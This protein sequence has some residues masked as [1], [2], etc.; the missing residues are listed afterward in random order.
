VTIDRGAGMITS[1]RQPEQFVDAELAAPIG[2]HGFVTGGATLGSRYLVTYSATAARIADDPR[3][4]NVWFGSQSV[5][6]LIDWKLGA[7]RL[8]GS[9]AALRTKLGQVTDS[10]ALAAITGSFVEGTL[11]ATWRRDREWRVDSRYRAR[12]WGDLGHAHR[13]QIAAEWRRGALDVQASAGVD[14][15]RNVAIAPGYVHSQS[16][17][18]KASIGSKTTSSELAIGV[19]A[20]AALGDEVSAGV[21][22]AG[23]Q[24]TPYTLEARSYGFVH[25]FATRGA[26]FGGVDGEVNLHGDGVRALLQIGC[27]R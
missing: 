1:S 8:D 12:L 20:T 2:E 25:A 9:V 26:W 19:A 18:Y 10:M 24:R 4:Q 23:D 27:S 3:L 17:V 6:A 7:W 5:F 11:R 14:V 15:H 22:D 16:F 13:A 21:S